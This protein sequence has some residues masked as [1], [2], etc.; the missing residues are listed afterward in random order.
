MKLKTL[1]LIVFPLWCIVVCAQKE[2]W[3]IYTGANDGNPD[4]IL[5][6]GRI[7]KYDIYGLNSMVM[8]EFEF[9][10]GKNPIGKLFLASN[11][12]LYGT[13]YAGGIIDAV[14][15]NGKGVLFEYDLI[16]N[17]YRV[18]SYFDNNN[19]TTNQPEGGVIEPKIGKLYGTANR[20]V[21]IYDLNTE[22]L[23]LINQDA[24]A[25][26]HGELMKASDGNLY[27]T[28]SFP[29]YHCPSTNLLLP[30]N[31]N[32][33]KINTTTNSLQ[34]VYAFSCS[35][36]DGTDPTGGLI[37]GL[38]GKLYGTALMGGGNSITGVTT[39]FGTLFEYDINNN[40]FSKKQNFDDFNLGAWPRQLAN[41]NDGK[42]YGVCYFGGMTPTNEPNFIFRY[43]T[44]FEYNPT[45]DVI[46]KLYDFTNSY[47]STTNIFDGWRPLSVLKTSLGQLMIPQDGYFPVKYDLLSGV[48]TRPN[49]STAASNLIEIC[50]KPSYKYLDIDTYDTCVDDVFS[51]DL[52]NTNANS[53]VWSHDGVLLPT[54]T[55]AVLSFVHIVNTDAGIYTCVMTND[56]GTTTTMPLKITVGCLGTSKVVPLENNITL[57]PNPAKDYFNI[58]INKSY[59]NLETSKIIITNLLGQVIQE[60]TPKRPNALNFKIDTSKFQQGVYQAQIKTNLGSWSSKFVKE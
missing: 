30:N 10:N 59:N 24:E 15:Q 28:S 56:C 22:V 19:P 40:V 53:Y 58:K 26:I 23:T 39:D 37:E 21:Y 6:Q 35:Y 41:G 46:D 7:I 60:E 9:T 51:Y 18:V 16:F 34:T 13:T 27:G 49:S 29:F 32:I 52:V 45:N 33:F 54:Q 11:G 38:P 43:G 17:K 20:S 14:S 55:T 25:T 50:R 44:I 31:G 36:T 5:D 57:Y 3:G 4:N 12:K 47:N 8:H 2:Y 42:L 1:L 48:L